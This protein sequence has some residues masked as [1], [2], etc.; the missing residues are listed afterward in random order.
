MSNAF[1]NATHIAEVAA[2]L[3][4]SDLVLARELSRDFEAGFSGKHGATVRVRVPGAVEA[5]VKPIYDRTTPLAVAEIIE[6]GLD[7]TLSDHVHSNVSLSEGDLSL[8]IEDFA[9]Q[10]LLPQSRAIVKHI[11][12]ATVTA[13]QA[14]PETTGITYDPDNPAA[15][16]TAIRKQLRTNGVGTEETL[17]AAVGSSVYADLLDYNEDIASDEQARVRGF[18]VI[19]SSRLLDEEIVGFVRPAFALVVRAPEVPQG[20]PF[21]AS[22]KADDFALRYIRSYDGTVAADRSLV[23]AFVAVAPMPIAVDR[24]DGT[25]DLVQHGGAVRVLTAV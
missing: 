4:G 14:T 18:R 20:A 16:F 13:L 17:V 21:G 24:E 5:G 23:S 19:E 2:K 22:V 9:S 6:Q 12:R 7:V 1:E 3:V 25:V 15:T 11:E 10:V 8:S